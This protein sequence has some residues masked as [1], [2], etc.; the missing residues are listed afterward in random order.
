MLPRLPLWMRP[1]GMA[2]VGL[3]GVLLIIT[4][5]TTPWHLAE[6]PSTA[7]GLSSGHVPRVAEQVPALAVVAV[8]SATQVPTSSLLMSPTAYIAEKSEQPGVRTGDCGASPSGF[9]AAGFAGVAVLLAGTWVARRSTMSPWHL[10]WTTRATVISAAA[11][12][13]AVVG[14]IRADGDNFGSGG[15]PGRVQ[16][17]GLAVVA[18]VGAL[19]A[20]RR[21]ADHD[22]DPVPVLRQ[23]P[24]SEPA[25]DS[26]ARRRANS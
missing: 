10:V 16:A 11:A 8:T 15:Q 17:V 21:G 3:A 5:T 9:L 12:T 18:L 26:D 19:L 23:P 2:M 6:C 1:V 20:L 14:R 13:V 22:S 24:G 4:L 25:A 7:A